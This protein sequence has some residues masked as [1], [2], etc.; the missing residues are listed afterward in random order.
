MPAI[1]MRVGFSPSQSAEPSATTIGCTLTSTTL[2][3]TEVMPIETIQLQRCIARKTPAPAPARRSR[4][5]RAR[6]S[7]HVPV[8]SIAAATIASV[9]PMRQTAMASG[10]ACESRTRGP[11]MEMPS[12]AAV[13]AKGTSGWG[14]ERA[15]GVGLDISLWS[16]CWCVAMV[17]C[18]RRCSA[19]ERGAPGDSTGDV[20]IPATI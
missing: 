15:A 10:S 3:A 13:S 6:Y 12:T 17:G 5:A 16:G 4:G 19:L 18:G 7:R 11:E 8:R 20:P 14:V 1:C 9:M 2:A